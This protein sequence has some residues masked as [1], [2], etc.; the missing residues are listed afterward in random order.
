MNPVSKWDKYQILR[1]E[2]LFVSLRKGRYFTKID[3]ISQVNNQ[4]P[5]EEESK[6]LVVINSH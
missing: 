6:K 5:L 2:D 3:L 4:L 1:V